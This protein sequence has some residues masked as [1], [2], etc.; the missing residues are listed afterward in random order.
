MGWGNG[1]G[2]VVDDDEESSMSA[3]ATRAQRS[4]YE[5]PR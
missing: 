1:D 3:E 2:A 5:R 4:E